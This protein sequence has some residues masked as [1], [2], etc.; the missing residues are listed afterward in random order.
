MNRIRLSRIDESF[1]PLT[2]ADVATHRHGDEFLL[3]DGGGT[4][5][6]NDT[7]AL[8]WAL[9]D[10]AQT[11]GS[12]ADELSEEYGAAR[13]V[14]STDLIRTVRNFAS[15]GLLEA[16]DEPDATLPIQAPDTPPFHVKVRPP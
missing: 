4:A 14:I 3:L 12:M 16:P 5:V 6:L 1:A 2:R 7:A 8:V 13:D 11:I 9:C 10:G 15:R